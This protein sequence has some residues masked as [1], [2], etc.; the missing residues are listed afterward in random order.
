[1][2]SSSV[3]RRAACVA[4]AVVAAGGGAHA[5]AATGVVAGRVTAGASG[6]PLA[7]VTV[8]VVATRLGA[9]TGAD[10]RY[11]IAA[12]PAGPQRLRAQRIGFGV[13]SANVSVVAGQTTTADFA[14]RALA[15][16]LDEVVT[17]GYGTAER[18]DLTGAIS[19]V[20]SEQL[21][22]TPAISVDQALLGRAAGVQ[23]TTSSGQPGASAMV[24]IRGGNSISAANEP[25]FVVDGVPVLSNARQSNTG[26]L[27]TQG[28]RG[29]NPIAT[30]NPDDIESIDILKDASAT[31]IYGA[32]AAN[33]VVLITTKR[34]RR[35]GSR[36]NFGS[37]FG[38]Q[39]VRHTLPVLDAQQ[40]ARVTNE[41]YVNAGQPA[42]F[43][44]DQIASMGAGTDW[45]DAIFR[46][47]AVQNYDL[48]FSGGDE[49][50]RYYISGSFLKNE[51]VV[52]NTN[53]DRGS[54]RLNLDQDFSD[55][56][57][58]GNT[59]T[60]TRS[61]GQLLPNGGAGSEASSVVLNALTASPVLPIYSSG[62][63][64]FVGTDPLTGRP[65]SNPVAT[66]RGITNAEK[67]NRA[68]G[69]VFAEYDLTGALTLRSTLGLDYLT[70][71][72]DYYSPSTT[73]PGR[74]YGG[75]GSRGTQQTT[76]WQN[77]NT[78]HYHPESGMLSGLD[79]LGGLT[80]Q[81]IDAVNVSGTAQG[82]LTDRLGEN[83]LSTANTFVGVWTGAPNS[84]LLSYFARANYDLADKYLFTVSG[85]VDGSSRF[86]KQNR[87]SLFPSAAVAWRASEEG[88][89]KRLGFF[90]DLKLRA[91][92][93]Q[94]G[95]QEIGNYASLATLGSRVYVFNGTRAIGFAPDRLANEDL[96]WETTDQFDVGLDL[97]FLDSRVA[98]TAD[99]YA[100]KTHDLLLN[101][102]IPSTSG[103]G[104]S[105]QNIGS[106]RNRGFELGINTVNLDGAFGWTSGLNISWN[107]NRV[108][109]LGKDTIL[110]APTGVGAGAVQNPTVLKVGEPIN[111]FYGWVYDGMAD[112]QPKYRDLN[113]DGS[114][115]QADRTIIGNAQP[116]FTGGLTN[117][118]TFRNF[119]LSVFVQWSVGNDIYN[120]N[121]TLLTN[122]AGNANQLDDVL[123]GGDGLPT[124]K[125]GNT[126]NSQESNL[127]VEDGSYVRGK[128]IRLAY[129]LPP[130][131]LQRFHLGQMDHLQLYVSAQNFFTIT[132]YTGF[133]PEISEYSLDNLAQGFDFGTYPQT[134][135]LTF[136]FTAGF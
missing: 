67:Q 23:V 33:G 97:A 134:R 2:I 86:G 91:S 101:V 120:I 59:L 26:T 61:Q 81:R 8:Q 70:S 98:I 82:F 37:Y 40:F 92:Y 116:D 9:V 105:L 41:A 112:G 64:F 128:N 20:T 45:Q 13:D 127:F 51:G 7:G 46:D 63:E 65:F 28:A 119:E 130:A 1:M 79:L 30:L 38:T 54:F 76:I 73:Y 62:G 90:D 74:T 19:S 27:Q 29:L 83:G 93:G 100:K 5:Q 43:T 109:N 24:R 99:Y 106:V 71:T 49:D 118:F 85:R 136:G 84:S 125:I 122:A 21:A 68:I 80:F 12:V 25:L 78:L 42:P 113:G 107:R 36:I 57:R 60:F 88:F 104:S 111:S 94:T 47:G 132:D 95:N 121:R 10:G 108:M 58:I 124:P 35:G 50:T 126:F 133:D 31:A 15:V 22:N 77:E 131:M 14:L 6:E 103:F 48:S 66:A 129:T 115:T 89:V 135:Q 18:R 72:Q 34:G 4:F 53:L 11:T 32:R 75:Y 123:A 87:Y 52:V 102:N 69:N 39:Q 110:I 16:Q 3:V 56:F 114:V 96:K 55:K 17:I 117:S 44:P